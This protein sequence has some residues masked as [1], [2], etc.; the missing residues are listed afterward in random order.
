MLI[1]FHRNEL[2]MMLITLEYFLHIILFVTYWDTVKPR[3][4]EHWKEAKKVRVSA[5]LSYQIQFQWNVEQR[6][7]KFRWNSN[8]VRVGGELELCKFKL[9]RFYCTANIS[10]ET[11]AAIMNSS[12]H[13]T[14]INRK[15]NMYLTFSWSGCSFFPKTGLVLPNTSSHPSLCVFI[16]LDVEHLLETGIV[17]LK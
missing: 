11:V 13:N 2:C 14:D 17:H 12:T 15:I 9:P 10:K 4:R 7:R 16:K 1:Q 6:E 8:L 5:E 3:N